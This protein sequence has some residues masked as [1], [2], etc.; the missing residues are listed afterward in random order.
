M[1]YE[2]TWFDSSWAARGSNAQSRTTFHLCLKRQNSEWTSQKALRVR[3]LLQW[4]RFVRE[5]DGFFLGRLANCFGSRFGTNTK[6]LR[7]LTGPI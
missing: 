4:G 1:C 5:G 3:F 7:G 6:L 2:Y